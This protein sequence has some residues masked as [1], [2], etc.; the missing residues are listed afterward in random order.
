MTEPVKP[1]ILLLATMHTDNL[2]LEPGNVETGPWILDRESQVVALI[3]DLARFAPTRIAVEVRSKDELRVQAQYESYLRGER[4]LTANE[5]DQFAYRLARRCGIER[6]GGFDAD[7]QLAW[8]GLSKLFP[9]EAALEAAM[10]E[11]ASSSEGVHEER[12][13]IVASGATVGEV[14]AW[15]NSREYQAA[16]HQVYVRIAELGD[17]ECSGGAEYT[18]SWYL[19]NL[20]MYANLCRISSPAERVFAIVGAGHAKILN[21][22]LV[23]GGRFEIADPLDYLRQGSSLASPG[24][25]DR[26]RISKCPP[27]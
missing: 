5:I 27:R 26:D 10:T 4:A 3:E 14:L 25:R 19:R 18:A 16:D 8:D 2:R 1:A 12:G 17:S 11:C 21:D 20:R 22:L 15:V 23:E 6:I 9:E 7:W 13:Q 24:D